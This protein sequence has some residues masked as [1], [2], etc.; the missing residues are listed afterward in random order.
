MRPVEIPKSLTKNVE[1]IAYNDME[2]RGSGF[3]MSMMEHE[4][5]MYLLVGH[6]FAQGWDIIDVTDPYNPKN[7]KFLEGPPNTFS[8]Q[9]TQAEGLALLALEGPFESPNASLWGV[10]PAFPY[11]EGVLLYSDILSCHFPTY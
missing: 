10:D 2:G 5:R 3:K 1:V 4:G 7:V 8:L 9:V 11:E 6:V